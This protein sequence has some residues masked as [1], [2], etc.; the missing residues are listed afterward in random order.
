MTDQTCKAIDEL[1]VAY[2]DGELSGVDAGRVEAHLAGCPDCREELRVLGRSLEIARSVWREAAASASVPRVASIDRSRRQFRIAA[3]A[4]A[5]S[6]LL[7]MA[8]VGYVLSSRG[9]PAAVDFADTTF[10]APVEA[11]RVDDPVLEDEEIEAV[12]ARQGRVARLQV[13]ARLLATQ[14]GLE[15]YRDRAQRYLADTY[16]VTT[17]GA[18]DENPTSDPAAEM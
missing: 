7:V 15:E 10:P 12:I 1:L 17:L 2:S 5:C 16:G 11:T 4:T 3:C 13:S 18:P 6:L 8:T 9:D 14:P